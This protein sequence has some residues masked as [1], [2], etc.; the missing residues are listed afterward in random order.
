MSCYF[1]PGPHAEAMRIYEQGPAAPPTVDGFTIAATKQNQT[2][3]TTIVG[4]QLTHMVSQRAQ[5][6][7]VLLRHAGY[8]RLLCPQAVRYFTGDRQR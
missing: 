2:G 1:G 4:P 6:L 5:N 8:S 7:P 3:F